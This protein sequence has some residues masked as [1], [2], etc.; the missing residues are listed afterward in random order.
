MK[1]YL[2]LLNLILV[3][4][5]CKSNVEEPDHVDAEDLIPFN[6]SQIDAHNSRNS[7]DW[8][9]SYSGVLPCEECVGIDTFL[10]INRD[11]TYTATQRFVDSA[12]VTSEEIIS[13][14]T[15]FWNEEG[16]SISMENIRGEIRTFRVNELFLTP[17]DKNG[18]ELRPEPGNNF[19]L[20]KQ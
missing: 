2:L 1:K 10:K 11:H 9:G 16:S 20:L 13:E 6:A 18:I 5:G 14:G 8:E 4:V 12:D 3:L 19:K 15:F 7:L 17:L